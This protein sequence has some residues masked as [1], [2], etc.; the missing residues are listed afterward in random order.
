MRRTEGVKPYNLPIDKDSLEESEL[1]WSE[2]RL[3][4]FL[5]LFSMIFKSI[6]KRFIPTWKS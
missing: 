4:M 1:A 6:C 2:G 5:E 3:S